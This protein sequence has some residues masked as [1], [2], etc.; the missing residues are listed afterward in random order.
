MDT[1]TTLSVITL[2]A[3]M[4]ASFQLSVSMITL[5]SSHSAGNK[6]S[7][8]HT[9]ALVF[10]FLAGTMTM[11]MLLVSSLA[12]VAST[13]FGR[14]VP[15]VAWAVVC[16]LMIGL[17]I[18]IW[19]FYYRRQAGTALWIP[20]GMARFLLQRTKAT[21]WLAESYS[22]GLV[23]VVGEVLF[24]IVP[25][26]AAALALLYLPRHLQLPALLWYVLI[27]SCGTALVAVLTSA[28]HHISSIQRWREDNKRFLQ[29]IAG[30]GFLV[31]GAFIYANI[32]AVAAAAGEVFVR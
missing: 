26:T 31:L 24:V 11:T 16:G 4:H 10:S 29:F 15:S 23:S 20:R 21:R 22:L 17:G 3:L 2:A 6:R 25:S 1:L 13:S 32:V 5:L 8:R 7:P 30:S 28:G 9:T 27:A 19:A 14:N 18:A 12:Y